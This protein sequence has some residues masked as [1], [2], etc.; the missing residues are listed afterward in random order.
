MKLY[1]HVPP[2]LMRVN[3]KK[4]GHK[5]EHLAFEEAGQDELLN[6]L[7]SL[8]EGQG[9]SIFATGKITTVEVRESIKGINGKTK[10]FYFRGLDP[11][12]VKTIILRSLTLKGD[13]NDNTY[14]QNKKS[15][16]TI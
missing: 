3:I 1:D 13:A 15:S 5:T 2:T 12:E 7:R 14:Q 11:H 6:W 10:S 8:I 16:G 9:L 4:Q